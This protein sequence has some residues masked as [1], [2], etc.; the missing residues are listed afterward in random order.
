MLKKT[1]RLI[2]AILLITI[3][4]ACTPSVRY[5][6]QPLP[7]PARPV[8]PNVTANDLA[9]L[10]ADVAARVQRRDRERRQYAEDLEIIILTNNKKAERF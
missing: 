1:V 10:N 2:A 6:S 5:V 3:G 4:S 7:M 9:P 8:L